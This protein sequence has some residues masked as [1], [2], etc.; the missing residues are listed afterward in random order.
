MLTSFQKTYEILNCGGY[1]LPRILSVLDGE[2]ATHSGD[3]PVLIGEYDLYS[4]VFTL[5]VVPQ[6]FDLISV[7]ERHPSSV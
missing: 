2:R 1:F 4:D 6:V 5:T 7:S 3:R